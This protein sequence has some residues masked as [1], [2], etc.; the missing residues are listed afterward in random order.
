M[1][2]LFGWILGGALFFASIGTARAEGLSLVQ[3]SMKKGEKKEVKSSDRPE[4][5][6]TTVRFVKKDGT[7]I[8]IRWNTI[9]AAKYYTCAD[10][11][12][13]EPSIS[14]DRT[15]VTLICR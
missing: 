13:D 15:V 1:K 9:Y 4:D 6:G 12:F 8:V 11:T 14:K 2:G 7:G 5:S 10:G 3:P